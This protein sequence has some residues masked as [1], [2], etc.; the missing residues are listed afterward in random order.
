[1][2]QIRLEQAREQLADAQDDAVLRYTLYGPSTAQSLTQAQAD[3]MVAA[4]QRRLDRQSARIED[5][6]K[7]IDQGI[8][9]RNALDPL[10]QELTFRET[11]LDLARSR[12][13]LVKDLM[14]SVRVEG[15]A[16]TA[17]SA[18]FDGLEQHFA[19][20]GSLSTA[21]VRAIETAFEKRFAHPMPIS[22]M[23]ETAVHRA[24]GFDHRGRVDVALSPDQ[25][26]GIWLRQ[27]LEAK[28]I[29]FYAFR[30]A[31]PGKA[32]GAHIHIG[33]GSTRLRRPSSLEAD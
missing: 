25:Q 13:Q 3:A 12:A 31:I 14:A 29:P 10:H 28:N 5:T 1:M 8:V 21:E 24:L 17:G 18:L 27:Y 9:A 30:A 4:A 11:T 26:E 7:L 6:Q 23:G 2:P 32:T 33:P 22:A 19:G 16:E 20:K 15:S